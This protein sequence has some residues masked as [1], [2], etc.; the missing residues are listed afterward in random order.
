MR[1]LLSSDKTAN[2]ECGEK[3]S[4]FAANREGL[5]EERAFALR[6]EKGFLEQRTY[7]LLPWPV[8]CERE[9]IKWQRRAEEEEGLGALE[10]IYRQSHKGPSHHARMVRFCPGDG[11]PF[12]WF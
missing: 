1:P 5:R 8:G 4:V 2:N 3:G 12:I 6:L 7:Q 10:E 11:K 9:W